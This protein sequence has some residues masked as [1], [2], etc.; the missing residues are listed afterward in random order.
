M[1]TGQA[2]RP[3]PGFRT[4]QIKT[5]MFD[6]MEGLFD[7]AVGT[8]DEAESGVSFDWGVYTTRRIKGIHQQRQRNGQELVVIGTDDALFTFQREGVMQ[9]GFG[10]TGQDNATSI[11]NTT[12]WS[13]AQWGD[14]VIASNGKQKPQIFRP[15]INA[16]FTTITGFPSLTAEVVRVLGPHLIGFNTTEADNQIYWSRQDDPLTWDIADAASQAG[17]LTIRDFKGPI[18]AVEQLGP[19]LAL[20]GEHG[21]HILQYIGQP[22]IF[23]AQHAVSGIKAVSKNS[24]AVVG[25][26]HYG[27]MESGIFRTDGV[28]FSMV[29]KQ[30]LG[31]WLQRNVSWPQKSRIAALHDPYRS[32]VKWSLPIV[33]ETGNTVVLTYCY[34]NDTVSLEGQPF[35]AAHTA[36]GVGTPIAGRTN[37]G[38]VM[39]DDHPNDRFPVLL[40]RP[41]PLNKRETRMYIDALIFRADKEIGALFIRWGDNIGDFDPEGSK[42]PWEVIGQIGGAEN[43]NYVSRE[44]TYVQ[45]RIV[46]TMDELWYLSGIDAFGM[47]AGGRF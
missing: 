23:G 6:E 3:A 16:L 28:Q 9:R 44:A 10:F 32:V 19:H 37:G 7:E 40:T 15:A 45:L 36:Q 21:M 17:E 38:V 24:I 4:L 1:F 5:G 11:E 29:A 2:V 47:P 27:L 22:F 20:Y 25:S 33:G 46:G 30:A 41:L 26:L 31:D 13:F 12:L 43:I 8:F 39:L 35:T 14:W 34:L 42:T 18:I